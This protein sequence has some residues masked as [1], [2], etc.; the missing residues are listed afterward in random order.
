M[1]SLGPTELIILIGLLV[2]VVLVRSAVL[3]ARSSG[4][5]GT[6][7]TPIQKNVLV[8]KK[9]I[10]TTSPKPV[11]LPLNLGYQ[12]GDDTMKPVGNQ[13]VHPCSACGGS[14][15]RT[16]NC[17]GCGGMGGKMV[18]KTHPVFQNGQYVNQSQYEREICGACGGSGQQRRACP[19]CGGSGRAR[20]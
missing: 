1:P 9:G 12:K 10:S 8:L 3:R 13:A 15:W 20:S 11:I 6:Q 4:T 5:D 7:S 16:E 18:F 19:M 17:P 14:G 2:F